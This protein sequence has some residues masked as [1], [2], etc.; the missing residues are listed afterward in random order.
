MKTF[1]DAHM[2]DELAV[3]L[4]LQFAVELKRLIEM[5]DEIA[6]NRHFLKLV[7]TRRGFQKL[8]ITVDLEPTSSLEMELDSKSSR[9]IDVRELKKK[10]EEAQRNEDRSDTIQE[11]DDPLAGKEIKLI[12]QG[13]LVLSP[14]KGK[15]IKELIVG[16]R[17]M[18]SIVDTNPRALDVAKAF[19]AY[20]DEQERIKPIPGRIVSLRHLSTGGYKIFAIVA[21]GIFMKIVEEEE[22]IRVAVEQ[23]GKGTADSIENTS[24][25]MMP[26]IITLLFVLMLL[27]GLIVYF[28]MG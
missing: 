26:L 17:V 10:E 23:P 2:R 13:S 6:I 8:N 14:I 21:K 9:K 27:V 18:I 12:L 22:S 19:K 16:D 5:S 15:D 20:D 3:G 25:A 28:V 24:R 1:L 11:E 7:Q 4:T